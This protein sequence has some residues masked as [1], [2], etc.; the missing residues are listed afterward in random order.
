MASANLGRI[1]SDVSFKISYVND[2]LAFPCQIRLRMAIEN[3]VLP[4]IESISRGSMVHK[5]RSRQEAVVS[6]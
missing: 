3:A 2:H 6:R 4:W 1:L 5:L